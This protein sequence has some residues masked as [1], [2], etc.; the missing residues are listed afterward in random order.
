MDIR[1]YLENYETEGEF[2]DEE[3]ARLIVTDM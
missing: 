3:R 2:T 1:D